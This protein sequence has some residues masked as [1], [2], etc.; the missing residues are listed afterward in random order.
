[1]EENEN[2]N[3]SEEKYFLKRYY[4]PKKFNNNN[5]KKIKKILSGIH[6]LKNNK[7]TLCSIPSSLPPSFRI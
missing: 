6:F 3:F 5:K 1:M 7:T 4:T 2:F